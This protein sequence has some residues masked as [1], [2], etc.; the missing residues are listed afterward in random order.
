MSQANE[1]VEAWR[2]YVES[3][4]HWQELAA[5]VLPK[6]TGCGPVYELP[7]PIDRPGESFAIADM[8]RIPFSDPHYH[9]NDELEIQFVL[10]GSGLWV[11]GGEERR[12]QKGDV[13]ILEPEVAYFT[14]V[15]KSLVIAAINSPVFNPENNIAIQETDAEHKFDQQ[16]FERLTKNVA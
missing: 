7:N 2:P 4:E 6:V 5:D 10:Q 9:T 13:A 8:R 15:E 14:V 1:I 12:L 3:I 16:Q 11:I